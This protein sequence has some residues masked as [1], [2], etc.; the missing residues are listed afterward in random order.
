MFFTQPRSVYIRK[1][2]SLTL[3]FTF[4]FSL[5]L[6]PR[7][8]QAQAFL[9]ELPAP[10]VMVGASPVFTPPLVVGVTVDVKNPLSFDFIV[11]V[12]QDKL[13]GQALKDEGQKLIK[14][15]LASLAIPDK[16]VWVNLSPYEKGRILDSMASILEIIGKMKVV[17]ERTSLMK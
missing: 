15:F 13:E 3:C 11:D 1:L 7:Y 14:Y 8:A 4:T 6:P 2:I 12:G 5:V 17:G 16:D 10:G 9:P